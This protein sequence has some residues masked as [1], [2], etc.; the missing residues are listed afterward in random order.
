METAGGRSR[1]LELKQFNSQSESFTPHVAGV[2]RFVSVCGCLLWLLW[3]KAGRGS[4]IRWDF[5]MEP[6]RG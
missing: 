4:A 6:R 1:W 3:S 5:G 2:C